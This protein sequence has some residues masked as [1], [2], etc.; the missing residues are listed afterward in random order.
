MKLSFLSSIFL[1]FLFGFSIVS[2][3]KVRK[4]HS[5]E[6]ARVIYS[7][8]YS[9]E[10]AT[11]MTAEFDAL[12]DLY[13]NTGGNT[14]GWTN[15]TNWGDATAPLNTWYG[16]SVIGT[17]FFSVNL[18][19]N[20]LVGTIP[21]S[22][23]N[24]P[25][26]STLTL[27]N[28]DLIGSIPSTL[29]NVGYLNLRDNNL[30]GGIPSSITTSTNLTALELANNPNLG[31]TIPNLT[32]NVDFI[33]LDNCGLTGSIPASLSNAVWFVSVANNSL[34]G[35]IPSELGNMHVY[36][37]ATLAL[38]FQNNNLSG[39]F[40]ETFH[41]NYCSTTATIDASNNPNMGEDDYSVFCANSYSSA[42]GSSNSPDLVINSVT[43]P[44][45]SFSVGSNN[46]FDYVIK[47]TGTANAGTFKQKWYL[48]SDQTA[49][50]SEL[51]GTQTV[52]SGLNVNATF[53]ASNQ[54]LNIPASTSTGDYYLI[55][56]T[57]ADNQVVESNE[58]NNEYLQLVTITAAGTGAIDLTP[59][60]LTLSS[61]SVPTG[62]NINLDFTVDNVGSAPADD[63]YERWYLSSD[64]TTDPSEEI[65]STFVTYLAPGASFSM[66]G[67]TIPIASS[68][69]PGTY[70]VILEVDADNDEIES[71]ENNNTYTETITVTAAGSGGGGSGGG[72]PELS[73]LSMTPSQTTI[74]VGTTGF[75]DFQ[76]NNSGTGAA[77]LFTNKW[78]LS[79][80]LIPD[81]AELL[82]FNDI[83]SLPTNTNHSVTNRPIAI[84]ANQA[85]TTYNLILVTDAN[86]TVAETNENNNQ[87][88]I[89]ITVGPPVSTGPSLPD[90]VII[91]ENVPAE[92]GINQ[93][94]FISAKVDNAGQGDAVSTS[95]L[96]WGV[97]TEANIASFLWQF[98]T[99]NDIPALG[100][101]SY[102]N[103]SFPLPPTC[104]VDSTYYI[105]FKAD[106]LNDVPEED[107]Q[108]NF[109]FIP[110]TVIP[111]V[112]ITGVDVENSINLQSNMTSFVENQTF[113]VSS[114]ILNT[115][116]ETLPVDFAEV[117]IFLSDNSTY[118]PLV[119]I[120]L[121]VKF[122]PQLDG[123]N[124][125][126]NCDD[127]AFVNISVTIPGTTP[128]G[129]YHIISYA[130]A[131]DVLDEVDE[132]FNFS[133]QQITVTN[134]TYLPNLLIQ[135]T[136]IP[137]FFYPGETILISTDVHN[138][139][140]TQSTSSSVKY[141]LSDDNILDAADV[142]L[143]GSGSTPG[144]AVNNQVT[145]DKNVFI[146]NGISAG[147]YFVICK[148]DAHNAIT[149]LFENDNFY[150]FP[151]TLGSIPDLSTGATTF[152]GLSLPI[153][154]AGG[155][156]VT[157]S[158]GVSNTGNTVALPN[159][160]RHYLSLDRDVS[161]NDYLLD[162]Q[163]DVPILAL[164]GGVLF[165]TSTFI[166]P[167]NVP[168]GQYFLV[169]RVDD[170]NEVFEVN[171]NN[172]IGGSE[173]LVTII[174]QPDL[175]VS[176]VSA[177]ST[178][179]SGVTH[180]ISFDV[181]NI[182]SSDAI[183]SDSKVFISS[184]NVY[185][186]SD[187]ELGTHATPLL[188]SNGV[189]SISLNITI[190]STF[191][192]GVY[193][194][195]F[196]A[197]FNDVVTNEIDETN[198]LYVSQLDIV[199]CSNQ[200]SSIFASV[201]DGDNYDF[202]GQL[203]STAGIYID[204]LTA[205]NGCDS[206]ITLDL[207]LLPISSYSYSALICDGDEYDFN[208][209]L[210]TSA[211]LH[212]DTLAASN[213]C[214]SIITLNLSLLP[215]SSYSYSA[216]IC[217]GDNYDFNGQLIA[218]AGIYLDTLSA[219]NGCDSIVTL[220]LNVNP[221]S[222]LIINEEICDGLDYNFN[223]QVIVT[224]GIYTD[225][226]VASNGC[227][228]IITLDLTIHPNILD[229]TVWN[230]DTTYFV[231]TIYEGE[232]YTLDGSNYM[233]SID[234]CFSSS[235]PSV[236]NGCDSI[237]C[238]DLTVLPLPDFKAFNTTGPSIAEK[239]TSINIGFTTKNIG[240]GDVSS[241]I[242]LGYYLSTDTIYDASD[243]WRG[244]RNIAGG[245]NPQQQ[246]VRSRPIDILDTFQEGNYYIVCR[247]DRLNE[248][249]EISETNNYAF[250]PIEIVCPE[251]ITTIDTGY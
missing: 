101:N 201:C 1:S 60:I 186:I 237:L 87:S 132:V 222:A 94:I 232:I 175:T 63:H 80:D 65:G 34:T 26:I 113:N 31:G 160:L 123:S 187:T 35:T 188:A 179:D 152:P 33:R 19:D 92:V 51:I 55:L 25:F 53:Y 102:R 166:V 54:Y 116:V 238:L 56:Q 136:T 95:K 217:D 143:G 142:T 200:N 182:G 30:T 168:S 220:N 244:G 71:N 204:T 106:G 115:G 96:Q 62:S 224:A 243:T 89:Q 181:E 164:G 207:T 219:T 58:T 128:T 82:G 93:E 107:E 130:D 234:S 155:E 28:N 194:L 52:S 18:F 111:P 139:G 57:D 236:V 173:F 138:N 22:L 197:D 203:I 76:I 23:G 85:Q 49:S 84:P 137:N 91:D 36:T 118:D 248:H 15:D 81:P 178:S 119:D 17:Q 46:N 205:T 45:T 212:L 3:T 7:G 223:G 213:G 126:S 40:P 247:A 249:Q 184:D 24:I 13:N 39:C 141:Y 77:G 202:N 29:S 218:T 170:D 44:A 109:S 251:Y 10:K 157:I 162:G 229:L 47:N 43:L 167:N 73:I 12:M 245:L 61:N 239:G 50:A 4:F 5:S 72:T 156:D 38:S 196:M 147:N 86:N 210:I 88:H 99:P 177:P 133:D 11:V 190:P 108:N 105:F 146:P 150:S 9:C 112:A 98:T 198:N 231:D 104:Q 169:S 67:Q 192:A 195:L 183:A 180:S 2:D 199:S 230:I 90:Y 8:E 158:A 250:H 14:G 64:L 41:T 233:E 97:S 235:Q 209:E 226:L 225:T 121:G 79:Q 172:N 149:E 127:D 161:A 75:F 140:L 70:Y 163:A 159:K 124:C 125:N 69:S 74:P 122:I 154:L 145:V 129:T 120:E 189:E 215:I 16:V 174:Q 135:N 221:I 193:H 185:D 246:A 48:S 216:S 6:E 241:R 176:N 227:D 37:D 191:S 131:T 20:N 103:G 68:L 228:S 110:F 21:S 206:I 153:T 242:L 42:C 66:S 151:I 114:Y 165:L 83:Y 240:S 134:S 32:N 100:S 78:Y 27:S 117:K 148:A 211:G 144:I 171:E 59:T 214:D 208:G